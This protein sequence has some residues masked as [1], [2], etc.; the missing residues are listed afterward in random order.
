VDK[1]K[2]AQ[3]SG[4]FWRRKCADRDHFHF[5]DARTWRG[6]ESLER[7]PEVMLSIAVIKSHLM[8]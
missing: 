2:T 1:E 3:L 6:F 8:N 4:F 7:A 5:Q